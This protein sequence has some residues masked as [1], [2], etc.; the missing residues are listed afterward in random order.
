MDGKNI[1]E[2]YDTGGKMQKAMHK[3]EVIWKPDRRIPATVFFQEISLQG[4]PPI[5][6]E[7]VR[8]CL[9]NSKFR[10]A[11]IDGYKSAN[12]KHLLG[13][14]VEKTFQLGLPG[15]VF[16]CAETYIQLYGVA[17]GAAADNKKF[18]YHI[19]EDE[20]KKEIGPDLY[21]KY[22]QPAKEIVGKNMVNYMVS[23]YKQIR[24][25]MEES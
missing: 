22:I 19:F 7:A 24:E 6:E 17:A 3:N 13:Y 10:I 21:A 2:I 23:L 1:L 15:E 25:K 14:N 18:P 5:T 12:D 8:K 4:A 20:I 11:Y 16:I 9:E